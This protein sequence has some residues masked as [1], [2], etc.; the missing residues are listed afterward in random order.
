[1][2]NPYIEVIGLKQETP[3]SELR[4]FWR[5]IGCVNE[6]DIALFMNM[7]LEETMIPKGENH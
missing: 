1:M 5:V 3:T 2:V 6:I 7:N 4:V